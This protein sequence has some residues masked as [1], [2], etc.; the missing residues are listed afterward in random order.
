M[1][2][3]DS[4]KESKFTCKRVILIEIP[5]QISLLKLLIS[6]QELIIVSELIPF[7][8]SILIPLP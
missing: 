8:E 7:L 6:M 4:R 5:E 2:S 1:L 3:I